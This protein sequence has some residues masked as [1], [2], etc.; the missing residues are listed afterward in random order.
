MFDSA[1]TNANIVLRLDS[2]NT[3]AM[4]FKGWVNEI[5]GNYDEA[6]LLY[7]KVA[8]STKQENFLIFLALAKRKKNGM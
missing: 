6:I 5:K 3:Q 2:T 4:F 7:D 1:L 8:A